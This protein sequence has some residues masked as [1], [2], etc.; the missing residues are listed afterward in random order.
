MVAFVTILRLI[1]Q[2]E[3]QMLATIEA[4]GYLN[5]A[6]FKDQPHARRSG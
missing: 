5:G 1:S 6:D 3:V 2:K 4:D